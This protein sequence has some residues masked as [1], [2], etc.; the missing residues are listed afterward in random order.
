MGMG[1][2]GPPFGGPM[3]GVPFPGGPA[4]MPFMPPSPFG[5]PPQFGGGLDAMGG[6]R[7]Q[8][9]DNFGNSLA[10]GNSLATGGGQGLTSRQFNTIG[11]TSGGGIAESMQTPGRTSLLGGLGNTRNQIGFASPIDGQMVSVMPNSV[12][13]SIVNER[14][15]TQRGR[16]VNGRGLTAGNGRMLRLRPLRTST[17]G[18]GNTISGSLGS[19]LTSSFTND[20]A[21]TGVA[22]SR[23]GVPRTSKI[24]NTV[25]NKSYRPLLLITLMFQEQ[26]R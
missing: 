26:V 10:V 11:G 2:F 18:L 7:R 20:R 8:G 22:S 9:F 3:G 24:I 19:S 14:R 16:R 4:G 17:A 23:F 25:F 12:A 1:P 5:M 13:N 6:L 21:L 15:E